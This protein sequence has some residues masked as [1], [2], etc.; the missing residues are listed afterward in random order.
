MKEEIGD[1][2]VS[3]SASDRTRRS[4]AQVTGMGA[5]RDEHAAGKVVAVLAT[6]CQATE[7]GGGAYSSGTGT[8]LVPEML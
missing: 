6:P 1:V 5:E 7:L 8:A 4:Q 2:N 3:H